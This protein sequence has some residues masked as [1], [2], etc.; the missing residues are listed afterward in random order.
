MD[1]SLGHGDGGGEDRG[2]EGTKQGGADVEHRVV[3][4]H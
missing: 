1:I 3:V 4:G 2:E